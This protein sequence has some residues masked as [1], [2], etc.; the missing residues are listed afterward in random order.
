M[1][2]TAQ[3]QSQVEATVFVEGSPS[4]HPCELHKLHVPH[5][6]TMEF[7]HLIPVAWQLFWQPTE[8]PHPGDDPNGRGH[9]WDDRGAW[10]CPTGHRNVH[11]LIVA[12]MHD[13]AHALHG[14]GHEQDMARLALE[15]FADVG[16]DLE[17][18][19]HAG[20]WGQI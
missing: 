6:L 19:V 16:G 8:E 4:D 7:H 1:N 17:A 5:T 3:S 9:L 15:R 14:H 11:H 18:L 13:N 2:A 20:K 10:L 12:A